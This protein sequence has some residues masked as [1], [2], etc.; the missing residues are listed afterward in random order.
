M[1][2]YSIGAADGS[3]R[4]D[5]GQQPRGRRGRRCQD[6][7]VAWIVRRPWWSPPRHS[8]VRPV[9][10]AFAYGPLRPDARAGAVGDRH[11]SRPTAATDTA[12]TGTSVRG[13]ST[14]PL[15]FGVAKHDLS[16]LTSSRRSRRGRGKRQLA[17]VSRIDAAQQWLDQPISD[18]S[19]IGDRRG[20]TLTLSAGSS[21]IV[22][23]ML[24]RARLDPARAIPTRETM[25]PC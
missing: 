6:D 20:P 13:G 7:G 12:K 10:G 8:I 14:S 19:P 18:F 16:A 9:S 24:G 22:S 5:L 15:G 25:A 21:A 17:G 4:S 2:A 3:R 11:C 1:L 23:T